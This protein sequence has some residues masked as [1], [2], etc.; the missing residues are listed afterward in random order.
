[1]YAFN[2]RAL[3]AYEKVGFRLEGT[4][5]E[6]LIWEG[7]KVDSHMMSILRSEYA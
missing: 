6:A 7:E 4:K 5:R 3:R 1:M 2:P